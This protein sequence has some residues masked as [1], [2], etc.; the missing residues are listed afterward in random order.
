[1]QAIALCPFSFGMSPSAP[2]LLTAAIACRR[3]GAYRGGVGL[4]DTHRRHRQWYRATI[5]P[6]EAACGTPLGAALLLEWQRRPV[7]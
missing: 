1:M 2:H 4:S 7:I 3:Y 5:E 6:G